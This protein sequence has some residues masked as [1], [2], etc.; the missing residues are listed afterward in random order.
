[1]G[2]TCAR[3]WEVRLVDVDVAG[4]WRGVGVGVDV[5]KVDG[6]YLRLTF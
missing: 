2:F 4:P 1:M 3:P 6:F 5:G